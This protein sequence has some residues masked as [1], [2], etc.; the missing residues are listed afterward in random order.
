M[1]DGGV[2]DNDD[3]AVAARRFYL[4]PCFMSEAQRQSW[5]YL[6]LHGHD[7]SDALVMLI[8]GSE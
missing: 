8:T 7:R 2:A 3:D 4:R 1:N 5:R 6:L